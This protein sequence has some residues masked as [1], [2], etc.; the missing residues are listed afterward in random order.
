[1]AQELQHKT[2]IGCKQSDYQIQSA[3]EKA[4][5][6]VSFKSVIKNINKQLF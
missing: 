2:Y 5:L 1:M 3:F 4:V 6:F